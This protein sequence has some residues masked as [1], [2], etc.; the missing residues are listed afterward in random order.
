LDLENALAVR[1]RFIA[2][3]HPHD[4]HAFAELRL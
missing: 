1:I 4:P 3:E 2:N